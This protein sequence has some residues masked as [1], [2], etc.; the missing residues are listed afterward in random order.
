[1]RIL[2]TSD[3][4]LGCSLAGRKR[5]EDGEKFLDWLIQTIVYENVE[6]L[7]VAGDVFDSTNPSNQALEQYYRFLGRAG[8]AGCRHIV[9]TAG[10]HDSPSLLAAPRELLLAL[11]IHVVGAV[12][13]NLEDEVILLKSVTGEPALIVCA[14]PFLRDRDIRL[15]EFGESIEEKTSALI[16]GVC[17]HYQDVC[18]IA[19]K[20]RHHHGSTIPIVATGH[21]FAA[22]GSTLTDDGVRDLS[23]GTLIQ[24]GID[25]FPENIDYLALGHL[26]QPQMIQGNL[27]RRYSGAPLAM[28]FG[29]SARD[30]EVIIVD[31]AAGEEMKVSPVVVPVFRSLLQ[32][33]GDVDSIRT[34][35]GN[36]RFSGKDVWVEI[37]L[38]DL[39]AGATIRDE[40]YQMVEGS[41]VE[42]LKV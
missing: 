15:S 24:V 39:H 21:F 42:V 22:G 16:S 13:D 27:T 19:E 5:Y 29:E 14:V 37:L 18:T 2:H 8:K 34:E 25:S 7:I 36:L 17:T 11:D 20:W 26:H 1:M 30:K 31:I 4:H 10:N 40:F 38:E 35:L 33:R 12:P 6:A 32:L 9:I 28:G 23:I 3:W 41:R